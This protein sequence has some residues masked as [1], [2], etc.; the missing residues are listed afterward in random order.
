MEKQKIN[1]YLNSDKKNIFS[2]EWNNIE[3]KNQPPKKYGNIKIVDYKEFSS[4]ILN[5]DINFV[6]DIVK[7]FYKGDFYIV[8]NVLSKAQADYVINE[9]HK[10]NQSSPSSF[11]KMVEGVPNFH[12]WIDKSIQ[13]KYTIKYSKHSTYFFN[14]NEDIGNVREIIQNACRP[15]KLLSGLSLTQFEKN[16]PKEQIIE[17]LQIARYPPHGFIEPHTDAHTLL[18]LVISGYLS[19]RGK[20]Y[21]EG[22]FYLCNN[23]GSEKDVENLIDAGDVGLFYAS[24]RHGMKSIDPDKPSDPKKKDG[25]WWYG[26]NVHHS[27]HVA[28]E[29][30]HTT[31]PVFR[32]K[33]NI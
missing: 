3:T 17:R 32:N 25:R 12:R 19:K 14:W 11:F 31:K 33:K 15:F 6:K 28:S 4:K 29:L 26:L 30:R 20:G 7:S 18:R 2:S 24:L 9:T 1:N 10:Y 23:D 27:D 5:Q 13:E 8:K 22:G 21:S 16:T